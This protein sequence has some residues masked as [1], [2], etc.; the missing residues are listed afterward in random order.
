METET[1]GGEVSTFSCDTISH[2]ASIANLHGYV[3]RQTSADPA[4]GRLPSRHDPKKRKIAGRYLTKNCSASVWTAAVGSALFAIGVGLR[5]GRVGHSIPRARLWGSAMDHA[6]VD[7]RRSPS[8]WS[9]C[10][11][12]SMPP[13]AT[14]VSRSGARH[15]TGVRSS[16]AVRPMGAR[17]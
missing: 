14:G 15:R 2:L 6:N 3:T 16:R 1:S 10:A 5:G 17:R 12:S 8:A 7:W 11:S 9:L 13:T 4:T